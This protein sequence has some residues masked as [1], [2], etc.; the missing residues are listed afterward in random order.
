MRK[1]SLTLFMN[2]ADWIRWFGN[3]IGKLASASR[4]SRVSEL[5]GFMVANP[6]RK[7]KDA[8][9]VGHPNESGGFPGLK[10]ET[11]GT[12]PFTL[13]MNKADLVRGFPPIPQKTRNGWGTQH[14]W[15]IR[16]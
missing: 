1:K 16:F 5:A 3:K 4:K 7:N 13:A 8:A 9:R 10:I 6:G 11:G 12:Q 2:K 15:L 14:F